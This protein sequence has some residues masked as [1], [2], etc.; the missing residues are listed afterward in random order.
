MC[1]EGAN[2][3]TMVSSNGSKRHPYLSGPLDGS[4]NGEGA[5]PSSIGGLL[6]KAHRHW[7]PVRTDDEDA[8]AVLDSILF[9]ETTPPAASTSLLE[10]AAPSK[11]AT[12]TTPHDTL[13]KK[14]KV[15]G[16]RTPSKRAKVPPPECARV[17]ARPGTDLRDHA[18][19]T[20]ER[21]PPRLPDQEQP[22]HECRTETLRK[23][24]SKPD[25]QGNPLEPADNHYMEG[26]AS[27]GSTRA[28][29]T[30]YSCRPNEPVGPPPRYTPTERSVLHRL[31]RALQ[32]D[33]QEGDET[34]PR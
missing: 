16:S 4:S 10:Q 9:G 29:L 34:R 13:M 17:G 6:D 25:G 21:P 33:V 20:P 27:S 15:E 18:L 1:R 12:T 14:L 28:P 7:G 19:P 11:L 23:T 22:V 24:P 3:A 5:S 32:G 8:K 30:V 26:F 31:G 2:F